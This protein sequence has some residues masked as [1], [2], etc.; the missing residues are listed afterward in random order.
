[1]EGSLRELPRQAGRRAA[2]LTD[3]PGR[4]HPVSRLLDL[5]TYFHLPDETEAR[6]FDEGVLALPV[7]TKV[8]WGDGRHFRVVEA[9]WSFS[10]H[11]PERDDGMHLYLKEI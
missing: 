11:D 5:P 3:A 6:Q 8:D 9:W 4:L 2:P 7:G 1:M 10:H